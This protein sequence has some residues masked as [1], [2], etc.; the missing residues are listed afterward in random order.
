MIAS[1]PV[2]DVRTE[3]SALIQWWWKDGFVHDSDYHDKVNTAVQRAVDDACEQFDVTEDTRLCC[4]W[5]G[6]RISGSDLS[7]VTA[8]GEKIAR[9]LG[10]FK[11]VEF[12]G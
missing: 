7:V 10:R 6:V 11:H 4:Q 12:I 3:H 5:E 9:A 1:R 8:A 2:V